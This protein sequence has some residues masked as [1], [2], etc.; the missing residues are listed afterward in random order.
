VVSSG[1]AV[2]AARALGPA[3]A[4]LGTGYWLPL[5]NDSVRVEWIEGTT[6][7]ELRALVVGD[8]LRGRATTRADD[9]RRVVQ[10]AAVAA[11]RVAGAAP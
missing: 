8:S 9:A 6:R 4:P 2:P 7:V 10:R 3:G 1:V 5:D 11:R